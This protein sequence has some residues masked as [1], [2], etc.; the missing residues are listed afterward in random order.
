MTVHLSQ[1]APTFDLPDQTGQR[2]RL[3][4]YRGRWVV[5]YFYP[6]DDTPGCTREACDFRDARAGLTGANAVVLG[7]SADDERSHAR[8]ADKHGLGF[9]LLADEGARVASAYGAYGP[10][11]LFGRTFEGV[12]RRT[13]LI[14]PEGRIARAWDG[15]TVEGHA[16]DV[17]AALR[18]AQAPV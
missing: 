12:L 5:L 4:D 11:T 8:F 9:P 2:H 14:D 1:P 6:K 17:E 7:V 15:V 3:E 13:F 18:E 10:K 16:A